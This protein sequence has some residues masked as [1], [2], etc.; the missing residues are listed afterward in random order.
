MYL[1]CNPPSPAPGAAAPHAA[2]TGCT[3]PQWRASSPATGASGR[4][5]R[6]PHSCQG[7]A[8]GWLHSRDTGSQQAPCGNVGCCWRESGW[9]YKCRQGFS[10]CPYSSEQPSSTRA[11]TPGGC[12]T[13]RWEHLKVLAG[14]FEL[15]HAYKGRPEYGALAKGRALSKD[16]GAGDWLASPVSRQMANINPSAFLLPLGLCCC[17]CACN[18]AFSGVR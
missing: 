1:T 5:Q 18:E 13:C 8:P 2:H 15:Q 17:H 11:D 12:A 7:S 6:G 3:P 16:S 14:R 4:L 9:L 10:R